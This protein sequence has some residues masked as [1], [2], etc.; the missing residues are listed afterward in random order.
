MKAAVCIVLSFFMVFAGCAHKTFN[1]TQP[2][3]TSVT[4]VSKTTAPTI[5]NQTLSQLMGLPDPKPDAQKCKASDGKK[6]TAYH[7]I[8]G[9]IDSSKRVAFQN[10]LDSWKN[11]KKLKNLFIEINSPGGSVFSGFSMYQSLNEFKAQKGVKIHCVV[12]GY[13]ASMAFFMLQACDT[14]AMTLTSVL[15]AHN[16]SFVIEGNTSIDGN[17]LLQLHESLQVITEIMSR[18]ISDRL[19]MPVQKYNAKIN[20]RNWE[21]NYRIALESNAIDFI[22]PTVHEYLESVKCGASPKKIRP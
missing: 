17:T 20:G 3:T 5:D 11:E 18:V 12:N 9:V 14:R 8:H 4:S 15:L 10:W 2:H 19:G 13:G 6:C 16:P 22:T 7:K 1:I 21:L